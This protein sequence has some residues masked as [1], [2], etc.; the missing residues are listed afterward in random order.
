MTSARMHRVALSALLISGLVACGND[1]SGSDTNP[2]L[3]AA[4]TAGG[5]MAR[6]RG[7]KAEAIPAKAPRTPEQMAAEALRVNP[8][9][10]IMVGF[11]SLGRTQVMAMTGQ[12]GATRTYM[13]PS[14]EALIIRDGMVVGT[15]GLGHDLSVAEPQTEPLIR[16]GQAGSASRVMRYFSGDGLERPLSFACTVTPGPKAGVVVESCKGHGAHFQNNYAPQGGHLPVSRQWLGPQLG[17]VTI[18]TLRP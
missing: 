9:P 2:V 10:L 14:K 18:Q 1:D 17:Y 4:R 7:D 12:N 5:T 13:A 3:I 8:A 6:I 16:A 11:E 15:R